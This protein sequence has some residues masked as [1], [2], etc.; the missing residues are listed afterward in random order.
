LGHKKFVLTLLN[1]SIS[2]PLENML[3]GGEKEGKERK[4]KGK[5]SFKTFKTFI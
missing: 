1:G 3:S 2:Q 5:S 4:K